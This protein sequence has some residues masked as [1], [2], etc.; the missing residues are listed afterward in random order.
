MA[1][2]MRST[3]SAAPCT[4]RS[5]VCAAA[6]R[7]VSIVPAFAI[8]AA[9]LVSFGAVDAAK[10]DIAGLTPCS[11]SKA[12]AKR[13]KGEVKGLTKRMKKYEAGS[14]PAVALE[15]TMERTKSRFAMY[16]KTGVL[17]GNDG[18][19][20]LIADPGLALKYGHAGEMFIPTIG[21]LY[22]AGYIGHTG[23][24]YLNIVKQEAKPVEKEIIID[25][26]L[27]IDLALKGFV[28]PAEV[29]A[30]LR[31]GTLTEDDANITIS[32]R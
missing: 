24:K 2:S 16:A 28:W 26:P 25:V 30:E 11:D 13:L 12:Y 9:A 27:A 1:L 8:G 3:L 6:P 23:R 19:P 31:A 22:I 15:A 7:E 14:A 17:C 5:T 4:R 18:L 32:P 29:I 21:F 20:H 10:A